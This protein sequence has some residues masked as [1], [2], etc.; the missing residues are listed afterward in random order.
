MKINA[1]KRSLFLLFY[2]LLVFLISISCGVSD[3]ASGGE[4][5]RNE[6]SSDSGESVR[7]YCVVIFDACGGTETKSEKV[8]KGEKV[9]KPAAPVKKPDAKKEYAF[10]GWYL[11]DEKWD[12]ENMVVTEDITLTARY[13][14]T[15]YSIEV[16]PSK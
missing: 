10:I 12:F 9:D 13:K 6:Q 2:L 14:E 16:L 3:G 5:H 4:S 8:L 7:E 1:E 11:A 15:L